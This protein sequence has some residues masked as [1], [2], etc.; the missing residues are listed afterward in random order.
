MSYS[1]ELFAILSVPICST[2][3]TSQECSQ[4]TTVLASCLDHTLSCPAFCIL[5]SLKTANL[6]DSICAAFSRV[7]DLLFF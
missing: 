4:Q 7:R 2:H 5:F 3:V 6:K 1:S